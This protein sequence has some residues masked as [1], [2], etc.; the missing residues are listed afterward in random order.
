LQKY[1]SFFVM[2]TVLQLGMSYYIV[3]FDTVG[4]IIT[5]LIAVIYFLKSMTSI[6]NEEV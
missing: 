4:V 1:V 2:F 5:I 6:R 3:H